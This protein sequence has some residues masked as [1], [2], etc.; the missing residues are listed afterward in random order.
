MTHRATGDILGEVVVTGVMEGAGYC[1]DEDDCIL[2]SLDNE[3]NCVLQGKQNISLE[4]DSKTKYYTKGNAK[5][6]Q[7][8]AKDK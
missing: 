8:H 4:S 1:L 7:V 3:V 2:F 5:G 6:H